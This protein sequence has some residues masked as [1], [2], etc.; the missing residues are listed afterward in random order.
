MF[1]KSHYLMYVMLVISSLISCTGMPSQETELAPTPR[2]LDFD[3]IT[4]LIDARKDGFARVLTLFIEVEGF[5]CHDFDSPAVIDMSFQN[6]LDKPLILHT[7]FLIGPSYDQREGPFFNIFPE[8]RDNSG[9][10]ISYNLG[11][12]DFVGFTSKADDFVELPPQGTFETEISFY[13]PRVIE[14]DGGPTAPYDGSYQVKFVYLN[15]VVGP[16]LQPPSFQQFDW[17]AWVGEV[18]SNPIEICI[19]NP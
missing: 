18:E 14:V 1:Q 2:A 13:F 9:Q 19:Q 16:A 17:N 4:R 7:Q 12:V 10:I 11:Y 8:I 3:S 15:S 6:M 5:G